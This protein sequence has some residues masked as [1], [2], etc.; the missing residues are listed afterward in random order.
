MRKDSCIKE[1]NHLCYSGLKESEVFSSLFLLG[2][3]I[4]HHIINGTISI[5]CQGPALF[6]K[7]KMQNYLAAL[8]ASSFATSPYSVL[9]LKQ[10]LMDLLHLLE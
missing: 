3:V 6:R 7:I 8:P 10:L 5:I 2:V 1:A 4:P 9:G